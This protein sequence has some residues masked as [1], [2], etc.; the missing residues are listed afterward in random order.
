VIGYPKDPANSYQLDKVGAPRAWNLTRGE[1][2]RIAVLDTGFDLDHPDLVGNIDLAAAWDFV[3]EDN[4]PSAV[5]NGHGTH[6]AG[7]VGAV[8]NGTGVT[9]IAPEA[10][11]V[12]IQVL[13]DVG[14]GT[15]QD[16]VEGIYYAISK[17]V[18]VINMS[19]GVL[20]SGISQIV[21]DV[22][23]AAITAAHNAG[24]VVVAAAG[25]SN[26]NSG[27]YIP[28]SFNRVISVGATDSLDNR[29]V[30]SPT[31]GSNMYPDFTAPGASIYSTDLNGSY[32]FKFGTSMASPMMAG[33]VGLMR[34]QDPFI[35][36]Q[37]VQLR[38]QL[39]AED[40]GPVWYDSDFGYGR[41]NA[42]K[43][44]SFDYWDAIGVIKHQ[45]L[46][47][48]DEN[49]YLRLDFD[50]NGIFIGGS[51]DPRI[52]DGG[53]TGTGTG[54]GAFGGTSFSVD[55]SH[56][57]DDPSFKAPVLFSGIR[58]VRTLAST[59][60]ASSRIFAPLVWDAFKSRYQDFVGVQNKNKEKDKE[61]SILHFTKPKKGTRRA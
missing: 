10:T 48:P 50:I 2:I 27:L 28:A 44:L 45:W 13:P 40:L 20:A 41:I 34:W 36:E 32:S 9:G 47:E 16:A 46:E 55:F 54:S 4:D 15:I 3:N 5:S 53:N 6:V 21:R 24:I 39:S 61:K 57:E 37:Q 8:R 58:P 52:S 25:N 23:Q 14:G 11:I 17:G 35:T 7:I 30:S 22:F 38:L 49:G 60:F 29:W 31:V 51:A 43:A 18:Q 56:V 26:D 1:G 19:L 33:L 42:F 12:P 59:P